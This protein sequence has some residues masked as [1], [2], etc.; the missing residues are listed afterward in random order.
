MT[1]STDPRDTLLWRLEFA[2]KNPHREY[3]LMEASHE[4]DRLRVRLA[5]AERHLRIVSVHRGTPAA[6]RILDYWL[7]LTELAKGLLDD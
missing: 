2:Y 5:T 4:I 6:N 1:E 7:P 3:L